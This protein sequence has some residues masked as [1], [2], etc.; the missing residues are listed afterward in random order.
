MSRSAHSD[1]L[2][3]GAPAPISIAHYSSAT[4]PVEERHDHWVAR[5][6]AT[7]VGAMF[8]SVPLEPFATAADQ[9]QLDHLTVQFAEGT[10]REF[11]RSVVRLRSDGITM[12][13]INVVIDGTMQRRGARP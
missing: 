8:D 12:L 7:S 6:V 10:A 4:V 11:D 9:I 5:G 1:P 13:G 3:D 2:H